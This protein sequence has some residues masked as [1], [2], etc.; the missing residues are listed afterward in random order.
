MSGKAVLCNKLCCLRRWATEKRSLTIH[1]GKHVTETPELKNQM[2]LSSSLSAL[3]QHVGH[4]KRC[5]SLVKT[6]RFRQQKEGGSAQA[7]G[8]SGSWVMWVPEKLILFTGHKV[9]VHSLLYPLHCA[10]FPPSALNGRTV[11]CSSIKPVQRLSCTDFS[12]AGKDAARPIK[13]L[14][15][16]TIFQFLFFIFFSD[17]VPFM[18]F[19][20]FGDNYCIFHFVT[21]EIAWYIRAKVAHF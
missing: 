9:S 7:S 8:D 17:Y 2:S 14:M 15:K 10:S 19:I 21:L 13:N 1:R 11:I 20:Y 3:S 16:R 12:S 4:F 6:R 5:S 18:L